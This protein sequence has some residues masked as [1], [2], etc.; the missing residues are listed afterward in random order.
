M[1]NVEK[2][3]KTNQKA[4]CG[5]MNTAGFRGADGNRKHRRVDADYWLWDEY[6]FL[7]VYL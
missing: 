7:I 1:L 2:R 4:R 6:V 5:G 3:R